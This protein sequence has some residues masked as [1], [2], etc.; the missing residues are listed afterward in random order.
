MC[1]I[2]AKKGIAS[3][4]QLLPEAESIP[5]EKSEKSRVFNR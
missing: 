2:C 5:L 3:Y 1:R 4:Q